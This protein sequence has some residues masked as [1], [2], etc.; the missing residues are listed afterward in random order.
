[1]IIQALPT[2][3]DT[4]VALIMIINPRKAFQSNFFLNLQKN[5]VCGVDE[6]IMAIIEI[7]T[8]FKQPINPKFRLFIGFAH[9]E[10]TTHLCRI[11]T[12]G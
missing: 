4:I 10:E 3:T 8:I 12:W 11:W 7:A 1:M 9:R 2:H 6:P 5:L